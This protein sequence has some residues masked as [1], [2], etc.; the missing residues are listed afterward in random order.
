MYVHQFSFKMF[1]FYFFMRLYPCL[2][3][4]NCS[5]FTSLHTN[6]STYFLLKNGFIKFNVST[7]VCISLSSFCLLFC[8]RLVHSFVSFFL[9]FYCFCFSSSAVAIIHPAATRYNAWRKMVPTLLLEAALII[10]L[11]KMFYS[12]SVIFHLSQTAQIYK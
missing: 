9:S 6:F 11:K 2:S 8:I 1:Y 4:S 12:I 3:L 7:L 10:F 5:R